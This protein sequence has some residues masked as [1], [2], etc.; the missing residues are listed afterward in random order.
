M[1]GCALWA[2]KT[3]GQPAASA[4]AVSPPAVEKASGKLLAPKT[5][6]GPERDLPLADVG[7]RQGSAV[8][9][10]R[11]DPDAAEVTLADDAGEEPELAGGAARSPWSLAAGSPV[12]RPARVTS[13]SPIG[14]D[15]LGNGLEEP[16]VGFRVE[17]TEG[18]VGRGGRCGGVLQLLLGEQRVAG[19][20]LEVGGGIEG[21]GRAC[22]RRRRPG[23]Q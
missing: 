17:R 8:R 2:L 6:T 19:L 9:Q 13:S 21:V 3:T 5:A 1:P 16:G 18:G 20:E 7:A 23:L 4:E 22:R 11:V 14:L 10:R 15:V 12:S